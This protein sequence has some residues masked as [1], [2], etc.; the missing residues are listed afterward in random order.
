[1][2]ADYGQSEIGYFLDH[3]EGFAGV[4]FYPSG[5]G[6]ATH[7]ADLDFNLLPLGDNYEP[8]APADDD[9]VAP[10]LERQQAL[11]D[12]WER[13]F[14]YWKLRR[15]AS[16]APERPV[17][18]LF[19]EA[20]ENEPDNAAQLLRHMDV[21]LS[22]A[23]RVLG[24]YVPAAPSYVLSA[25]DLEDERWALRVWHADAWLRRR[26]AAF[27]FADL[28][29]VRPD[30][31]AS[32]DPGRQELAQ[33]MS[34]NANLT[35]VVRDGLI[36]N[37]APR[38]YE[39]LKRLN[40]GLRERARR[41]LL[42]H[43]CGMNRVPLPWGG[44]ARAP[45]DLSELL[46]LDVEV[47]LCERASR[48]EEAVTAAQTFVQRARLGL[49]GS[50]SLPDALVLLWDRRFA[51]FRTWEACKRREL[52]RENWIAWNEMAKARGTEAYRFLESELRRAD[53]TVP[54]P[55]G[56]TFWN[57]APATSASSSRSPSRSART[58][59]E[60]PTGRCRRSARR[61]RSR[62]RI[63]TIT[64]RSSRMAWSPASR[65]IRAS[66][67]RRSRRAPTARCRSRWRPSS[68]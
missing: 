58:S 41:A 39:D 38:R 56:M 62:R 48:V 36:E 17:W 68:A 60:T 9:R 29:A 4:S 12:T 43:L 64:T 37:G 22:H 7:R 49:E 46:L 24:Y 51:T 20:A 61:R 26:I 47:G 14:D 5:G 35:K 18:L 19:D 27:L 53:L 44:Y 1:V 2:F 23:E 63:S 55:G 16:A 65:T 42:A 66:R 8:P 45:K 50:A 40:D 33:P 3:P 28:A 11:F 30:L 52:Y 10:S 25:A 31:W 32:D 59:G 67:T 57:G 13:T 6:Y 54:A 21:D 34:G 15:R